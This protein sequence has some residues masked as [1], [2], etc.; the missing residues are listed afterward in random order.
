M[1]CR[2]QPVFY[3]T[4]RKYIFKPPTIFITYVFNNSIKV[5][6]QFFATGGF[7]ALY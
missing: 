6:G 7:V 3:G 1:W 5:A 2:Y 4:F